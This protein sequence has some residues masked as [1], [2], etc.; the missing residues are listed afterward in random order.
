MNF[1]SIITNAFGV[2]ECVG[3]G[4]LDS[5]NGRR[6][7]A[8]RAAWAAATTSD[9]GAAG[10]GSVCA[11]K[12]GLIHVSGVQGQRGWR[13]SGNPEERRIRA[14]CDHRLVLGGGKQSGAL[15]VFKNR[16]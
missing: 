2:D 13:E 9:V 10:K 3:V 16:S 14:R 4:G 15:I 7:P 5:T 1:D 12:A 6:L 11:G 8:S